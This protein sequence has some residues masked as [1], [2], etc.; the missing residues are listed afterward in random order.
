MSGSIDSQFTGKSGSE[1]FGG[2]YSKAAV[3]GITSR[4]LENRGF[5]WLLEVDEEDD[6]YGT[7]LL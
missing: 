7:S 2:H 3:G 5:G 4:F 1:G 6:N